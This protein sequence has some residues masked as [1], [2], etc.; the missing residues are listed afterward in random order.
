MSEYEYKSADACHTKDYLWAPVFKIL[1]EKFP[2]SGSTKI[3]DVGCGNAAFTAQLS[4]R[5]FD[6][7]GVDTSESGIS[8]A[9][10]NYPALSVHIGSGYDDLQAT[11]GCFDAVVSLEVIE[12]LYSPRD[13]MRNVQ[14]LRRRFPRSVGQ[15]KLL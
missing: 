1:A 6:V 5:G 12:H 13:F 7:V 3:I 15:I 9:K 11:F 2:T 8:I 4:S 10:A 14:K